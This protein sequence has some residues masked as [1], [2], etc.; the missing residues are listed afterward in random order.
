L[1]AVG[2]EDGAVR[3]ADDAASREDEVEQHPATLRTPS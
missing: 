1:L 2:A 3:A